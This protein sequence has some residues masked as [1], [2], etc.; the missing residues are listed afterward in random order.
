VE[1]EEERMCRGREVGE[2]EFEL[3]SNAP[4]GPNPDALSGWAGH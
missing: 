3:V 4:K 1:E 2:V